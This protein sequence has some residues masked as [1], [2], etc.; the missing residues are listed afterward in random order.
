M[1]SKISEIVTDNRPW[2]WMVSGGA[3]WLVFFFALLAIFFLVTL[4]SALGWIPSST[5]PLSD[6]SQSRGT[7]VMS[8]VVGSVALLASNHRQGI[9]KDRLLTRT[10][11]RA[12]RAP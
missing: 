12:S 2:Y 4:G 8:I 7:M 6:Q 1:R 5:E 9:S 10:R 11:E 3:V